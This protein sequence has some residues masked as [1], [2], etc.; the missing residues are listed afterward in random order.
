MG[1]GKSKINYKERDFT[2]EPLEEEEIGILLKA[3]PDE[4]IIAS[5]DSE[6]REKIV[7]SISD[8]KVFNLRGDSIFDY[9]FTNHKDKLKGCMK[10]QFNRDGTPCV[11][12][13]FKR[14]IKKIPDL[15]QGPLGEKQT[16]WDTERTGLQ[17]GWVTERTGLQTQWNKERIG[18]Q[19]GWDIEKAGLE[20]QYKTLESQCNSDKKQWD[21]DKQKWNTEKEDLESGWGIERTKLESQYKTLQSQCNSDKQKWNSDK[22]QWDSDI[23]QW[24]SYKQQWNTEKEDLE[25]QCNSDKQKW[26][27][28]KQKWNTEK[29]DL[30]SGWNK[31]KK[32]KKELDSQYDTLQSNYKTLQSQWN[33]EKKELKSQYDTLQSNYKTLQSQL[34]TE[35]VDSVQK[36]FDPPKLV[37]VK[38]GKP[39]L[40]VSEQECKTYMESKGYGFKSINVK[41]GPSGCV[42]SPSNDDGDK[43]FYNKASTN[44]KCIDKIPCIQKQWNTEKTKLESQ[45]DTENE[46]VNQNV[47]TLTLDGF[48]KNPEMYNKMLIEKMSEKSLGI[49]TKN[50]DINIDVKKTIEEY[51]DYLNE[52]YIKK[53]SIL[54]R[55]SEMFKKES[56]SE[57]KQINNE[58]FVNNDLLG[59]GNGN[60]I[61]LFFFYIY[62][63]IKIIIQYNSTDKKL[64]SNKTVYNKFPKFF[65]SLGIDQNNIE[66]TLKFIAFNT[67]KKFM[68]YESIHNTKGLNIVLRDSLDI[69]Q[70]YIIGKDSVKMMCDLAKSKDSSKGKDSVKIKYDLDKGSIDRLKKENKELKYKVEDLNKKYK[71]THNSL[72]IVDMNYLNLVQKYKEKVKDCQVI[73]EVNSVLRKENTKLKN[74]K[75]KKLELDFEVNSGEKPSKKVTEA[76]CKAWAG[77][78]NKSWA[79]TGGWGGDPTGCITNN[80]KVWFNTAVNE[81]KCGHRNYKCVELK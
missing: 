29:E 5:L 68:D 16:Q 45:L 74:K 1:A 28:D 31:E 22:K 43:G 8:E 38:G 4:N 60:L 24:N 10:N 14:M 26:D 36:P 63:G 41:Y 35:S 59:I 55:I 44:Y 65:K 39:D 75:I 76:E 53:I 20:S 18:L 15:I 13:K 19:S 30:E 9:Y 40:S 42:F 3:L 49:F 73:L 62:L 66:Y 56:L 37:H 6:D 21:S 48:L 32:E 57:L 64:V 67:F 58:D 79:G 33:T 27:S 47:E 11:D 25:S 52:A 50:E 61:I 2:K 78:V 12:E 80:N 17:A 34:D 77:D 51:K 69:F 46:E 23:Q 71:E 81:Y 54:P 70:E 7:S 72:E